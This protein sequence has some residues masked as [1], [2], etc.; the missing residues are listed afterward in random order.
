M[1]ISS[2]TNR[3]D[4]IDFAKGYILLAVCLDHAEIP[5][6]IT[7]F[8]MAAF[9][10]ISG[11]LFNPEHESSLIKYVQKKYKSLLKPYFLLSFVFLL[12]YPSLYDP[13][14]AYVPSGIL[15]NILHSF[16]DKYLRTV[17]VK[18]YIFSID[19]FMGESSPNTNPLWFVYTLFQTSCV[20]AVIYHICK[21][22]AFHVPIILVIC[23]MCFVSG[24]YLSKFY[25]KMPF[26]IDTMITS[27]SFYGMGFASRSFLLNKIK[28]Y[29]VKTVSM[30]WLL[31]FI[32]FLIGFNQI[33]GSSIGY[34]HNSLGNSFIGYLLASVFGTLSCVLFFYIISHFETGILAVFLKYIAKNGMT[35]LAIHYVVISCCNYFI[36]GKLLGWQYQFVLLFLMVLIVGVSIPLFNKHLYWMIGKNKKV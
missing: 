30:A 18:I 2:K 25:I 3:I 9:F 19:I 24:W 11:L 5:C 35:V 17:I 6:Y 10:F 27:L 13:S 34:I 14:I 16:N 23:I 12:L 26:K 31:F 7:S 20:F 21:K 1:A 33:G 22:F 4:W 28:N 8:H 36:K 32:C 29:S 15:N